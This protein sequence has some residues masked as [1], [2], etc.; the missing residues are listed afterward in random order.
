M[1]KEE[2]K[3]SNNYFPESTRTRKVFK[4]LILHIH[5]TQVRKLSISITHTWGLGGMVVILFLVQVFTGIVLR[6]VYEP[7]PEKAYN[8]IL[9]IQ[10]QV[11]F[12][13]FIRNMHHLSGML[14]VVISFLHLLRVFFTEAYYPPRHWNWI[15]GVGLMLTV[16]L[17][18]FSGYL[19]P[20]DQ[21]SYWAVTVA[22]SML[23]YIPGIGEWLMK[24][25][26]GGDEVGSVT[27][28]NFYNYHTSILPLIMVILMGFHFWKVRKAGGV[29][30]PGGPKNEDKEYVSTVPHLVARELVVALVL[31]AVIMLFSVFR[32]APLLERANPALSPNPAKAPWY[33]LGI[34]ELLMHFHP[35]FASF[36]MPIIFLTAIIWIPFTKFESTDGGIWFV[37][38]RGKK[39]CAQTAIITSIIIPILVLVN[40]FIPDI[41]KSTSGLLSIIGNGLLPVLLILGAIV[42]W[43]Y[44]MNKKSGFTKNE[45][46]QAVFVF[47]VVSYLILM[48]ISIWFRG[49]GMA[50]MWPWQV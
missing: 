21:L 25:V 16:V 47:F 36:V 43:I 3:E 26:R 49:E 11:F 17:S 46:F 13:Q 29:V 35:F 45:I 31:L 9:I 10:N 4:N 38:K 39:L 34:Q 5:P 1:E 20:W 28:L 24:L 18:N 37:S 27:L 6:F 12:G 33:F 19:L 14:M 48:F 41:I 22:T 50:L 30:I 23:H 40:N 2:S 44:W 15:I 32:D 7:S 8:S 42:L